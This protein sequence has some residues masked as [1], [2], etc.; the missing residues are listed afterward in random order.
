MSSKK[1]WFIN[2]TDPIPSSKNKILRRHESLAINLANQGHNIT[3]ITDTFS[4]TKKAH[5]SNESMHSSMNIMQLNSLGY[6]KNI[7]VKRIL[8]NI[9]LSFSAF[10]L[11]LKTSK[12]SRPDMIFASFPPIETSFVLS[13]ITKLYGVSFLIDFRDLHPEVFRDV[14]KGKFMKAFSTLI[15]FPYRFMVFVTLKLSHKVFTTSPGVSHFLKSKY[16]LK[17]LPSSYYH[18]Y[19]GNDD[20]ENKQINHDFFVQKIRDYID[21]FEKPIIFTYCGVLSNRLDLTNFVKVFQSIK[22][23]SKVLVLCG[24]GDQLEII[25]KE[26]SLQK[27]IFISP[28]VSREEVSELYSLSDYGILP[29]PPAIDFCL[30][31]PTKLSELLYHNLKII[32]SRDTYIFQ[33]YA[34]KIDC[35]YYK[36]NNFNSL[37][38]I[39]INSQKVYKKKSTTNRELWDKSFSHRMSSTMAKEIIS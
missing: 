13:I 26:A 23:N 21:R 5:I 16:R 31:P 10:A 1:I 11:I 27:N 9:L 17:K 25:K 39:V 19:K 15:L 2:F 14:F 37:R 4:H 30:A 3:W 29:Y 38:E 36:F 7:S 18:W 6:K 33:N 34:N 22:D 32:C 24:S 12:S 35:D 8:H 20:L 28:H